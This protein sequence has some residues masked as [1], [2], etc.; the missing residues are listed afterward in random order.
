MRVTALVFTL[1]LAP[2]VNA[3]CSAPRRDPAWRSVSSRGADAA[4]CISWRKATRYSPYGYDHLVYIFNGCT[5]TA[6]CIVTTDAHPQPIP[7][8]VPAVTEVEVVTFVGSPASSFE[9]SVACELVD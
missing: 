1:A 8:V 5:K 3:G 2:I 4:G 9:A 7:V 6:H